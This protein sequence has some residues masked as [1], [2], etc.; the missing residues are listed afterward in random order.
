M[1]A[2]AGKVDALLL[3]NGTEGAIKMMDTVIATPV[4]AGAAPDWST[5]HWDE[6]KR[7]FNSDE[8]KLPVTDDGAP[9]IQAGLWPLV[10]WGEM[11]LVLKGDER[12]LE[13]MEAVEEKPC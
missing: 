3:F 4:R 6:M 8:D 11:D 12:M 7:V 5:L 1:N 2:G 9:D 10:N 13:K